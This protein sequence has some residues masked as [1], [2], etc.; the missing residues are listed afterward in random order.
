MLRIAVVE[1]EPATCRLLQDYILRFQRERKAEIETETF[2]NG[3]DLVGDYRPLWDVIL[4]DI[5][6]PIMDGMTAAHYIRKADQDVAI[7]FI[8]NMA[9]YAIKGYE[10]NALDFV[11]KPVSYFAFA[12]KLD[13]AIAGLAKRNHSCLLLQTESGMIRLSTEEITFI[14]VIHH[15]LQIH[16]E[17][18]DYTASG[19]LTMMEGRLQEEGFV[20]CNKGYLVNLRH[21]KRIYADSVL[22]GHARLLISRRR[23]EE[24]L[25]AVTDYYGGGGR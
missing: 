11:L 22:V 24:F 5:E 16:T 20:R 9:K 13:K 8:T 14:E 12:M 6:M 4:L 25:A 21:V 7:I 19:T 15:R 2:S 18:L 23:R 10:V 17:T 3:L 1:D